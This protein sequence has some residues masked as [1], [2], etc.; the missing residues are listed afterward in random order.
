MSAFFLFSPTVFR[1]SNFLFTFE[2]NKVDANIVGRKVIRLIY[3]WPCETWIF[4][5]IEEACAIGI[6]KVGFGHF[7]RAGGFLFSSLTL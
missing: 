3:G 5:F 7:L 6:E 4:H 1:L 2:V